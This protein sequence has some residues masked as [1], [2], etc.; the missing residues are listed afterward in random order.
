MVH[1]LKMRDLV[2]YDVSCDVAGR[3]NESPVEGHPTGGR[4]RAPTGFHVSHAHLRRDLANT[5]GVRDRGVRDEL[6]KLPTQEVHYRGHAPGGIVS[7]D[8]DAGAVTM[9]RHAFA[10]CLNDRHRRIKNGDR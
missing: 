7:G 9:R 4:A 10:R 3:K 6:Q 5:A 2:R 8:D 1:M